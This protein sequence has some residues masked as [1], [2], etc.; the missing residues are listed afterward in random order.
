LWETLHQ[1]T[2]EKIATLD[3]NYKHL[4]GSLLDTVLATGRQGIPVERVGETVFK[5]LTRANPRHRYRVG[6]DAHISKMISKLPS[7]LRDW[8]TLKV[9]DSYST[10]KS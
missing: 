8:C 3:D 5:A 7:K 2:E 6:A 1:P 9:I 10:N 4:Y